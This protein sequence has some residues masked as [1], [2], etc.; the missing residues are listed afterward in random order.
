MEPDKLLMKINNFE[1]RKFKTL[2]KNVWRPKNREK[3]V[4]YF[5]LYLKFE[6][7]VSR[8]AVFRGLFHSGR[9]NLNLKP[10]YD[11]DFDYKPRFESFNLD[12]REEALDLELFKLLSILLDNGS[13]IIVSLALMDKPKLH[14]ET[15]L[16]LDKGL[17]PVATY[18]GYI[19][20]K[21]GF[22]DYYKLW[23]IREGGREGP[24]ALQGERAL[25]ES[26]ARE[27]K[28]NLILELENYLKKPYKEVYDFEVRAR[29]RVKEIL[30]DLEIFRNQWC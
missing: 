11:I 29:E 14:E 19:L 9:E 30:K 7:E 23:L 1:I 4:R 21:C 26:K 8:D 12:L 27:A 20:Y 18:L 24:P 10:Y 3:E 15:F 13:K 2:L 28:E 6:E 5:E 17:P 16:C 25:D 22:G